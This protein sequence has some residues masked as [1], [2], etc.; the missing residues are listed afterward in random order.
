VGVT[1]PATNSIALSSHK[2]KGHKVFWGM[3]R[4]FSLTEAQRTQRFFGGIARFFGAAKAPKEPLVFMK[5]HVFH[6]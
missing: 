5:F 2:G 6:G 1:N 4:L 3:A